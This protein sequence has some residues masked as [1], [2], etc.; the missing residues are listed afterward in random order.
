MKLAL[1]PL[2]SHRVVVERLVLV[3]PDI[4]LETNAQ[5]QTNWQFTPEAGNAPVSQP[6][7]EEAK[8]KT[9]TQISIAEVSLDNGTLTWRDDRSGRSAVLGIV[10]LRANAPSADA[11]MHIAA[12]A[13]LMVRRSHWPVNSD[14]G[15][16]A[17]SRL[18]RTVAGKTASGCGRQ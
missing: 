10:S 17:G 6:A 5:G 11:N 12:T 9:P 16:L 18:K 1:I 3:K 13:T 14:P 8:E 4:V 2:L 7:A 15:P